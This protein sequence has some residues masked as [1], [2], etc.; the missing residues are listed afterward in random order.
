VRFSNK[1]YAHF[2][3]ASKVAAIE[4]EGLDTG[5]RFDDIKEIF[6]GQ[7]SFSPRSAVAKRLI[8][9]LDF[10]DQ[11]FPPKSPELRNRSLVQSIATLAAQMVRSGKSAGAEKRFHAFVGRFLE[12]YADQVEAGLDAT[13]ADY[14]QFQ[15][16]INA[17]VRGAA[18]IRHGILLRKL[19]RMDPS[20]AKLLDPA[21]VTESGLS[22][23]IKRLGENIGDLIE[24]VNVKY[25]S[26]HGEDLIKATNKTAAAIR[27]LGHPVRDYERYKEL[28][29][30]LYFLFRE[31]VGQRL[32]G[33]MPQSFTDIN[34]LRTDLQHD[35]DHGKP[36][37]VAAK[38]RK[39]STAFSKYV[40]AT[41]PTTLEPE[42]FM[43]FHAGMLSAV[44]ADLRKLLS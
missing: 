38:R 1:R 37:D 5:L 35:V 34:L 20:F 39:I 26:K 14:V 33:N 11:A 28:I 44:E 13:D 30:D 32:S 17:N 16:T 8:D 10:L 23:D 15:R 24:K 40:S 3:V 7:S 43:I 21:V 29:S 22:A 6:E 12:E 4:I 36:K 2:D 27:R 41:T 18:K 31:G 9:T 19:L 42:H 25:S